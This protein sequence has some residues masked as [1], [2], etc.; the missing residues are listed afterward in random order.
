VKVIIT[1]GAGFLGSH[2]AFE[3]EQSGHEVVVF[4]LQVSRY[5]DLR[6]PELVE[7]RF[8]EHKDA[9]I[10]VHLAAKVGRLFG[11]E[12]PMETITDNVG[13]TAL[14]A[15]ACGKHKIRLAYASTSEIYG[16]NGEAVCDEYAGPFSWPH[17]LYGISK[18]FGEQVCQ[19]Y[20][21]RN[22]NIF[23]FSMPYGPGLPAGR[24]RAAIINMLHQALHEKAIPVH[25]GAERSWCYVTDTVRAVRMV[26]ERK[27]GGIYNIGRDDA[28]VPMKRV[29]ELACKLADAH[30]FLIE[31]VPAPKMQTVVKRLATE[32][33]RSIGWKPEVDL[34]EGMVRTLEWVLTLD[35][36][37]AVAA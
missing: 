18:Y 31:I 29:A 16:D 4:D 1:G 7:Q 28:A 2:L 9:D 37:G 20:A 33:I 21:P 3:L 24:G 17:N 10:C 32:R 27:E 12:D 36:T 19:H 15:Q 22:L 8:E 11:E 5:H 14:V 26:L 13:I 23:R 34:E 35:E 6:F 25:D 30:P